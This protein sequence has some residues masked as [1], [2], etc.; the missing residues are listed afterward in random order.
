MTLA[1]RKLNKNNAD[2]AAKGLPA[3]EEHADCCA[4]VGS[5]RAHLRRPSTKS[6]VGCACPAVLRACSSQPIRQV[7]R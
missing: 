7:T 1:G 4:G 5:A 2:W 6:P 3:V